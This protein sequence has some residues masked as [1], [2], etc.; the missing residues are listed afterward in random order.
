MYIV[1]V[2]VDL[3][4]D[5]INGC[6]TDCAKICYVSNILGPPCGCSLLRCAIPRAH[7]SQAG[8]SQPVTKTTRGSMLLPRNSMRSHC[9]EWTNAVIDEPKLRMLAHRLLADPQ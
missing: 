5:D 6:V 7:R 9:S 1:L 2:T 3:S 8:T 4:H